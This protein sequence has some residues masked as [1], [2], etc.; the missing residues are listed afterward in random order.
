MVE[1][2]LSRGTEEHHEVWAKAERG[3]GKRIVRIVPPV[4]P[5]A[6]KRNGHD[7]AQK[8]GGMTTT[9]DASVPHQRRFS[10]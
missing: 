7:S 2:G 9:W 8:N 1:A 6:A 3:R 4:D 5:V 10:C